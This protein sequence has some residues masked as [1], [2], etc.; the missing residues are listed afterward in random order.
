MTRRSMVSSDCPGN[1]PSLVRVLSDTSQR[2]TT[3]QTPVGQVPMDR[4][5]T[6]FDGTFDG[7]WLVAADGRTTYTND[8]M[9]RLLGTVPA[10]MRGRPLTDFV[11]KRR[12]PEVDSF[13]QR[14]R[15]HA[16]ERIGLTLR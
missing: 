5:H 9:A 7:V 15:S 13:L 4:L 10:A 1:P 3:P 12:W 11:D 8:A 16:G 2:K 14:Q 6:I